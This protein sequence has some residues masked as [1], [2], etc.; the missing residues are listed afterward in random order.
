MVVQQASGE[1]SS[2]EARFVVRAAGTWSNE[3]VPGAPALPL[4]PVKGHVLRLTGTPRLQHVVRTPDVYLVPRID[5]TLIVGAT[6]EDV[7]LDASVRAGAVMDLLRHAFAVL[8][9]VAEL[10]LD[11]VSVGFRPALRDHLPAIGP[12]RVPGLYDAVGHHRNGVLLAPITA[13]L[14]VAALRTGETGPDLWDVLPTRFDE[15][16]TR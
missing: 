4:R 14:L 13:R 2:I 5:G 15:E 11:E 10:A 1:Q 3:A 8:P 6:S 12:T 9:A 7:G 16:H